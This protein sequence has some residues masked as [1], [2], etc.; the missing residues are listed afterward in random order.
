MSSITMKK[1][2][3]CLILL[4]LLTIKVFS[5]VPETSLAK[6]MHERFAREGLKLYLSDDSTR[7]LKATG[8]LQV[9]A[10]YNWNDPGSAVYGHLQNQ[11]ADVGIRTLRFQL[12]GQVTSSVYMY[13]QYG[14]DNFNYLSARKVGSFF[15]DALAEYSVWKKYLSIGGGLTYMGGPLRYSTQ[16]VSSTLM[17]D[18]PIYQ[19][20][21]NDQT[22][23]FG[24]TL[25]MYAKGLI[26]YFDYR[27]S[28]SK[29]LAVQ[30]GGLD[31]TYSTSAAF[32][33]DPASL[34][35][36]TYFKWH[37]FDV[38]S[39]ELAYSSGTYLG[40]KRVLT[41]GAGIQYQQNAMRYWDSTAVP[42]NPNSEEIKKNLVNHNL[43]I[44]GVDL[45]YD[46]YLNKEKGNAIT[47]YVAYLYADYGK[48]YLR[49]LGT[50]NMNTGNNSK[51]LYNAAS[52]GNAFPMMGTGN[53]AYMQAAYK[54][55]D[56]LFGE[57]G[58][59][60]PYFDVQLSKFQALGNNTMLMADA[61]INWLIKGQNAKISLNYQSRPVY[62]DKA[63]TYTEV[64]SA[65]RGLLFLQYQVAF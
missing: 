63:G 45:F 40:K 48:N 12:M 24:R 49:Y 42:L 25:G 57:H 7:W 28:V 29:P 1:T 21:I 3:S 62:T 13:V 38:E 6:Q 5:Q 34:Q 36:R 18:A 27:I 23:Q 54:F 53:T 10:R 46:S 37:F 52:F 22:D 44:A 64:P 50:M 15:H 51:N 65:R 35:Y 9:Q 58:T 41:L 33:P 56:K 47:I 39:N 32:S 2:G 16:S 60:Q 19:Q 20:T 59:L 55:K 17:A 61:G 4:L 31:T 26:K 11:T 30:A 43:M 8:L 14:I